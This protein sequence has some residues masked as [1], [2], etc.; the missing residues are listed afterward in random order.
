M[1][2][3]FFLFRQPFFVIPII[4]LVLFLVPMEQAY[5][6][7]TVSDYVSSEA[8][9]IDKVKRKSW[10]KSGRNS[11]WFFVVNYTEEDANGESSKVVAPMSISSKTYAKYEKGDNIRVYYFPRKA[12]KPFHDAAK[13]K[14]SFLMVMIGGAITLLWAWWYFVFFRSTRLKSKG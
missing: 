7:L 5:R 6:Y 14:R 10:R 4:S 11:R 3:S 9:I 1:R 2:S 8:I 12:K 13:P